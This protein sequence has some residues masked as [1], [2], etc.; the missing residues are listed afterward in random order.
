MPPNLTAN[1]AA[2]GVLLGALSLWLVLAPGPA[3]ADLLL[4]AN[5]DRL[6]G[7]VVG[8]EADRLVFKA[9]AFGEV[10]V[11]VAAIASVTTDDPVAVEFNRGGWAAGRLAPSDGGTRLT[12][13]DGAPSPLDLAAVKAIRPDAAIPPG[14]VWTGHANVGLGKSAGNTRIEGYD[15]DA[16][17]IGRGERD[18]ITLGGEL[19]HEESDGR[20]T[21]NKG[22]LRVGYNRF[23]TRAIYL[24]LAGG[25]DHDALAD[26]RLRTTI[27]PGAGYQIVDT[28]RTQ[29]SFE[30]G[31]SYVHEDF[32]TAPDEDFV[33]GRWQT[34]FSMWMFDR[35]ARL[36]HDHEGIVNGEDADKILIRSKSGVR[37]P[38]RDFLNVTF[39]T[40]WDYD[41]QPAPG[42]KKS[43]WRYILSVGYHW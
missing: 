2:S 17:A 42:K 12:G 38:V 29:L 8:M 30:A 43:D 24:Y 10:K 31:P 23:V 14:L 1:R 28:Q 7:K 32:E 15:L 22:R 19:H 34:K 3:V 4:L 9:E 25:A 41:N 21:A 36:F 40:N 16:E 13:P 18:R 27:G 35:F 11:P 6:T 33:A 5:G 20:E 26:L 39:Q 37:I